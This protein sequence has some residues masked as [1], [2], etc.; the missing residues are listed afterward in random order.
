MGQLEFTSTTNETCLY[1]GAYTGQDVLIC[2]KVDDFMAAGKDESKLRSL[3]K[4]LA[5]KI[6]IDAE[7][8]LVSHYNGIEIV[9]D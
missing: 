1:I 6:N 8:G 5:T 4:F 9:K 7:V 2:R 3:F